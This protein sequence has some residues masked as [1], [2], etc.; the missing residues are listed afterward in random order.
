[1]ERF[2]TI[3]IEREGGHYT[4]KQAETVLLTV[5]APVFERYEAT[6][7]FPP[8][9]R[10]LQPSH[11]VRRLYWNP[12]TTEFLMAGLD[13]HTART[14]EAY[15]T[16]GYRSFLQGFWLPH[17]PVLLLRPFWNP[18][19]PYDDFDTAA[20]RR[21]FEVQQRFTGILFRLRPPAGWSAVL[22]ATAPYLE[23]L[24]V[25]PQGGPADPEAVAEVSLTPPGSL[26]TP[27]VAEALR[28]LAVEHAGEVCPVLR[29]GVLAGVHALSRPAM[30]A[31]Q[32]LLDR[33]GLL[34]QEGPYRP[35]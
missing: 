5:P 27:E 13:A 31:A 34:H 16:T 23:A 29:E 30:H 3:V 9:W 7:V 8:A 6:S 18:E 1:M 4:V 28:A 10:S 11:P 19:S 22:N 25:T 26:A 21:S 35:H 33:F 24:G 20:R 32:A 12:D 2:E 14:A 15:G 17:P